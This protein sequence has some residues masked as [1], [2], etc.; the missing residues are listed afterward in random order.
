M[1]RRRPGRLIYRRPD[2]AYVDTHMWVPKAAYPAEI[3]ARLRRRYK[4][5]LPTAD[6]PTVDDL[7]A[8][9]EYLVLWRETD[10]HLILPRT[11]RLRPTSTPTVNLIP[12]FDRHQFKSAITL[13]LLRDDDLQRRAVAGWA[14]AGSGVLS[15]FCGAGKALADGEPVLTDTGWLPI[16]QIQPGTLAAGTDGQLYPVLA[17]CPQGVQPIYRVTFADKTWVDTTADHRWTFSVGPT[18]D[19]QTL[20]TGELKQAG[21]IGCQHLF[22]PPVIGSL[23]QHGPPYQIDYVGERPATCITTSSPDHLFLTRNYLPTHNTVCALAA[24]AAGGQPALIIVPSTLLMN[25]WASAAAKFLPGVDIGVIHGPPS[26][27]RWRKPLVIASVHTLRLHRRSVTPEIRSWPGLIVYDEVHHLPAVGL[28]V[29]ADMFVGRRLGLSATTRRA[30][31]REPLV[32]THL[33][34]VFYQNLRPDLT[35]NAIFQLTPTSVNLND[36]TLAKS[37]RDVHGQLNMSKIRTFVGVH[38]GRNQWLADYIRWAMTVRDKVLVLTHSRDQVYLLDQRLRDSGFDDIALCTGTE[39][40]ENRLELIDRHRLTLA[41]AH[42]AREALDIPDLDLLML[43]SPFGG[44]IAGENGM[45][46]A[47]GRLLRVGTNKQAPT[48][49]VF[50]DHLI[51]RYDNMCRRTAH[52]LA[53]WPTAKGGPIKY[54]IIPANRR[55]AWTV[56]ERRVN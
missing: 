2:T 21:K 25:Q 51:S 45:Q 39:G 15:L 37:V 14:A 56:A 49:L 36:P 30:D 31:G 52:M 32:F 12:A 46:Q 9:R 24:V 27:W 3:L 33:G 20:T 53:G 17:V 54:Q 18:R 48:V 50:W 42:L 7:P 28:S 41:T 43:L 38:P 22:L 35:V 4:Y 44:K 29:T 34:P 40:T 5:L 10:D 11:V 13:D 16:E 55:P 1:L 8:E 26:G 23:R 6:R 19:R 47:M